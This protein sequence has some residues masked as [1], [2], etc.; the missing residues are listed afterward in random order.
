MV[1]TITAESLPDYDDWGSDDYWS[2]DD[3]IAWHKA[4]KARYGVQAANEKFLI[5]YRES[6]FL[7]AELNYRTF[8]SAFRAYAQENGFYDGLYWGVLGFVGKATAWVPTI[9]FG[10]A[11]TVE[12][13]TSSL[14]YA[15]I[16]VVVV[17]VFYVY[18]TLRR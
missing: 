11:E 10:I 9:G 12:S 2:A 8:N 17:L 13:L 18:L 3:W 16:L 1:Y 5:A 15:T 6:G 14:K 4:L 7:G